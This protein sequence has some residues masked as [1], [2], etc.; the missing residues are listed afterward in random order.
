M[1]EYLQTSEP[2]A[3]AL[4]NLIWHSAA[5]KDE[6][7]ETVVESLTTMIARAVEKQGR[8]SVLLSGGSTP[9]IA[10]QLLAKADLPWDQL[11][12]SLTDER[13]VNDGHPDSNAVMVWQKLLALHPQVQWFP[14]WQTGWT[15]D[16]IAEIKARTAEL[17]RPFDVVLL[18]MGEDG[19]FASLFPGCAESQKSLQCES[20][21]IVCTQAPNAPQERISWSMGSLLQAKHLLLYV[22]GK[23]KK[24]ILEAAMQQGTAESKLPIG[25][26]L[27][28]I[29]AES[30][31]LQIFW[32]A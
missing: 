1:N 16:D 5:D 28:A 18:G 24:E 4:K 13:R 31:T 8:S 10:Y 12:V 29:A 21:Q 2:K 27:H 32:S 7:A 15:S 9:Q 19:H 14:L 25:Y 6:L 22:T 3:K 20:D 30:K 26:L 11:Q 17:Q 23:R